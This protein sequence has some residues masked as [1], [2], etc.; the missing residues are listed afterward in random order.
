MGSMG[1]KEAK[2]PA[3]EWDGMPCLNGRFNP[4]DKDRTWIM[5]A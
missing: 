4:E 2:A 5:Y 1:C 3:Q